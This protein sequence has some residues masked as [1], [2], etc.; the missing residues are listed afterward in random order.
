MRLAV[1]TGQIE[2]KKK[3]VMA[4]SQSHQRRTSVVGQNTEEKE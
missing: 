1:I 4:A 3:T 2:L